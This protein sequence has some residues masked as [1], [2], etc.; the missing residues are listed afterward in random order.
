MTHRRI[1]LTAILIGYGVAVVAI[2]SAVIVS[3]A[4]SGWLAL[5]VVPV[6]LL[7]IWRPSR[8]F[9]V[10]MA[11]LGLA[12]LI[13]SLAN[14]PHALAS[15]ARTSVAVL[16]TVGIICETLFRTGRARQQA[17]AVAEQKMSALADA[18]QEARDWA[19]RAQEANRLKTDFL[20]NTSHELRT[21]LTALISS[22]D[23][24]RGKHNSTE[25]EEQRCVEIAH[26]SAHRLMGTINAVLDIA[27][28]EAGKYEIERSAVDILEVVEDVRHLCQV[29]AANR[30][31]RF[32]LLVFT[33]PVPPIAGDGS[34]IR[35]ILLNLVGNAI[36]FTTHGE[37]TISVVP[38]TAAHRVRISV[39]DTGIGIAREH[40]DRL[41]QPFT[42]ANATISRRYGGTGLG[43]SISRRLADLMGATL[44]AY[45]AGEGRGATFTLS[46]PE[47]A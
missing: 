3:Q 9:W 30:G 28:I 31:L 14:H 18:V 10:L 12:Y 33:E 16:F 25:Q 1:H 20:A 39:T 5:L 35:Q 47:F 42:Q 13:V 38:D 15:S 46:L 4:S 43:L 21:P 34:A 32:S 19:A 36:K 26:D 27:K 29:P 6:P 40:Q 17:E 7:T 22:L 23:L 44:T 45:S 2:S 41:F 24:L 11:G 8:L 37:I